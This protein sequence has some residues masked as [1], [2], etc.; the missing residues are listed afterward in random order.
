M[1]WSKVVIDRPVERSR[2]E[3]ATGRAPVVLLT[4]P[5][6]AGKS[7]LA[8]QI[9]E[10]VGA[11]YFDLEH[12][13]HQAQLAD[14]LLALESLSGLVVIDE[15]QHAPEL[16]PVLRVLA[17]RPGTLARFLILGS[18]SPDLVGLSAETLAGRIE[19]VELG[20][21]RVGDVGVE[22]LERLWVQG[23]FPRAFDAAP[24]ES[25]IWRDNYVATFLE[26]DLAQLGY[27]FPAIQMRRFWTMLA[28][29]HGQTWN[30]AEL[31][32]SLGGG[33]KV[34]RRYLDALTDSLMIRQLQPWLVNV[35]K[36]QVRA[37]KIYLR[38][39][40]VLHRLLA[41]DSFD[42]VA[43]HP[44]LGASWEGFV[45]EQL[46]AVLGSVPLYFWATHAG[47]EIDLYFVVGGKGIGVEIKRTSNPKLTPSIRHALADLDLH[48]V[49]V[50]Y[51]G[52]D[53]FPLGERVHAVGVNTLLTQPFA[54]FVE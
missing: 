14:P 7:T 47:A 10:A 41:I 28:H 13:R 4:G 37:P 39:S 50:V 42:D 11:H 5:R 36:R 44:K 46:S 30:G 48:R 25:V 9:G 32:R 12:P 51:P 29:W 33:Q 31:A 40:G 16:F 43:A 53:S 21:L 45:I 22:S 24:D 19:M 26:R 23:A 20:G 54:Q 3:A 34:I 17:D 18:A 2:V 52:D 6:Q 1:L 27:R 8:R 15:A 49:L 38:D 35:G